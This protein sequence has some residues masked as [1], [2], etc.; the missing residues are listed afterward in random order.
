LYFEVNRGQT[1]RRVKFLSR[2]SSHTLFLT[3]TEAVLVMSKAQ[4]TEA[5]PGR[6]LK[7]VVENQRSVT[8]AVLRTRFIGVNPHS[9]IKGREEFAGKV[10]Y[11]IGNDPAKWRTSVPTYAKVV[12]EGLYP[13]I[14]LAYY[15]NQRQL[16]YDFIVRPGGDPGTIWLRVDG[17]NKLEVDANGDLV[18]QTA[19]G[20]IRQRKPFIYQEVDGIRQ[21]VAGAY[22]LRG[23]HQVGFQV[24]AY[25]ASRKLVIDPAL[26]YSTYLGNSGSDGPGGIAVDG[27][28]NAYSRYNHLD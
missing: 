10:N 28:D 11:F 1:D 5:D 25:D 14:D 4:R 7:G 2:G 9:H 12:Y 13:K 8:Q 22:V 27:A 18:L 16:E 21:E 15:G 17:P 19:A 24:A 23:R 6:K 3:P 26:L 20:A